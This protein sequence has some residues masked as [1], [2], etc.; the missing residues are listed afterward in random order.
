MVSSR[1]TRLGQNV[2]YL[3]GWLDGGKGGGMGSRIGGCFGQWVGGCLDGSLF[4]L[5]DG[6]VFW[7]LV[8]LMDERLDILMGGCLNV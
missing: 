4:Q 5:M 2:E 6:W 7:W 3:G 1:V 8:V